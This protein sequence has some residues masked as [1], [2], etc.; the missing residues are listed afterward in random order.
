M[1]DRQL[2]REL[3]VVVIFKLVLLGGLWWFFIRDQSVHVDA[4]TLGQHLTH[5]DRSHQ[6]E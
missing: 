5:P 4:A 3:V 1:T 6:G 2:L